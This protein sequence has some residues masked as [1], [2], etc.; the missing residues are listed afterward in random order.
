MGNKETLTNKEKKS[1]M[2]GK[3]SGL[4]K[5][6]RRRRRPAESKTHT[7]PSLPFFSKT[8]FRHWRKENPMKAYLIAASAAALVL[9]AACGGGGGGGTTPPAPPVPVT[10][11]VTC[12]NGT[13]QSGT[14]AD[15]ASANADA[16]SKCPVVKLTSQTPSAS[17]SLR[18]SEIAGIALAFDGTLDGAS[19]SSLNV[20]LAGA[21][22]TVVPTTIVTDS[23][24]GLKVTPV[25][26]LE[27][28]TT[29][30]VTYT[31]VKDSVGRTLTGTAM[32][33]TKNWWPAPNETAMGTKVLFASLTSRLPAT[34]MS[35]FDKCFKD[36]VSEGK[37]MLLLSGGTPT[38]TV[39]AGRKITLVC[40]IRQ[41]GQN[42]CLTFYQDNGEEATGANVNFV[43]EPF[44]WTMGNDQGQ[45]I[46]T[47]K[48]VCFQY[49]WYPPSTLPPPAPSNA[50]SYQP[51]TCPA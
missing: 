47:S 3:V 42:V 46:R 10:L 22:G 26:P 32:V 38:G 36:F 18:P 25:T 45:L 17:A 31:G 48:D 41:D 16:I 29:L 50:W 51:V 1:T 13:S 5:K 21:A 34:C 20:K 12:P 27:Y 15:N 30:T 39:N 28:A 44:L 19:V 4:W 2:R 33:S 14:G 23:V 49:L 8:F 9:L 37:A 11:S 7:P 43:S 35:K 40:F 24:R 6:A